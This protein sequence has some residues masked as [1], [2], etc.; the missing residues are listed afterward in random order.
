LTIKAWIPDN[1]HVVNCS[2]ALNN[3]NPIELLRRDHPSLGQVE[4]QLSLRSLLDAIPQLVYTSDAV[5]AGLYFNQR[6]RE[7]L[8]FDPTL[9]CQEDICWKRFLHSEDWERASETWR[10]A[11]AAQVTHQTEFRIRRSDGEYRWHLSRAIP[12]FDG[13]GLCK[14]WIGTCTDIH[15]QKEDQERS[16]FLAEITSLLLTSLD[17]EKTLKQ[18]TRLAVSQLA[19]Y[20]AVHVR[21]DGGHLRAVAAAHRDC[22]LE[23]VGAGLDFRSAPERVIRT[24]HAEWVA[25][26]RGSYLCVAL[27]ARG[28]AFGSIT[29][30][31]S[32]RAFC[33][34]EFNFAQ[35][36]ARRAACAIDNSS[37]YLK[38]ETAIQTKNRMS[39]MVCH[40]LKNPLTVIAT[41]IA[42]TRRTIAMGQT[43]DTRSLDLIERSVE[44]MKRLASDLL[45]ETSLATGQLSLLR[46]DCQGF[47][48]ASE[49]IE[50][51]KPVAAKQNVTLEFE[52][53]GADAEIFCDRERIHQVFSNLFSNAVHFTPAGGFIQVE[54]QA[55]KNAV[56]Y[57]VID[58]GCGIP[59]A[60]L[61]RVFDPHWQGSSASRHGHGLGLSI[62]KGIIEAH[63]GRISVQSEE[64]VGA[65]MI[66]WLPRKRPSQS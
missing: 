13:D 40:D 23:S 1:G 8:G 45:D 41:Q 64:G 39:E 3:L 7:L 5:G 52:T 30:V 4:T 10:G 34:R 11:V 27:S 19:T 18:V 50:A 54:A 43:V 55:S 28:Q 15:E 16:R 59:A 63:G 12:V 29:L 6:W 61:P 66:F 53:H 38:L 58:T 57:Q 2:N 48:L 21:E 49:A 37:L 36:F 42:L 35:E 14:S 26:I 60:H 46:E 24:G 17:Y 25:D 32:G 31:Q 65:S 44:T 62:V 20:A 56:I 9:E 47:R 51:F 33:S 22:V